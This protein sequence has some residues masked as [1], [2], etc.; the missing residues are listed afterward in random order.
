MRWL[1]S[2]ALAL[3]WVLPLGGQISISASR[4]PTHAVG[5]L[6]GKRVAKRL[7]VWVA[8]VGWRGKES[9][10]VNRSLIASM[11]VQKGVVVYDP[12]TAALI[13]AQEST[14]N[15]W[16]SV[17]EIIQLAAFSAAIL[18]ETSS[19][20][21]LMGPTGRRAVLTF[22]PI[23]PRLGEAF[24]SRAPEAV[25]N[26]AKLAQPSEISLS[27]GESGMIRIFTSAASSRDTLYVEV[28]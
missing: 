20:K 21:E 25:T 22:L 8:A 28:P 1:I 9:R 17:G 15:P 7:G 23:M 3:A 12:D 19:G 14:H 4:L 5:S 11:M 6:A 18:N 27:D 13:V 10:M 24:V 16:R 2:I 26:I